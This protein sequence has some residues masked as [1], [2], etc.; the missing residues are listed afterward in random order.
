MSLCYAQF[1][2]DAILIECNSDTGWLFSTLY[3]I[4]SMPECCTPNQKY[5][6]IKQIPQAPL[7]SR[8]R[9]R[10]LLTTYSSHHL[11]TAKC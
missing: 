1:S 7:V 11:L 5:L 8:R 6:W 3:Q 4:F 10:S 2:V 9:I